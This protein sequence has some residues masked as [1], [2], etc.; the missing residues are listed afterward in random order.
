MATHQLLKPDRRAVWLFQSQLVLNIAL[1]IFSRESMSASCSIFIANWS[2]LPDVCACRQLLHAGSMRHHRDTLLLHCT[3]RLVLLLVPVSLLHLLCLE[4]LPV[5]TFDLLGSS[6]LRPELDIRV[7]AQLQTCCTL[8]SAAKLCFI[9]LLDLC[10]GCWAL[11]GS[12]ATHS[13]GFLFDP[14]SRS[15]K[16]TSSMFG[17]HLTQIW[18][19]RSGQPR[20]LCPKRVRAVGALEF[21]ISSMLSGRGVLG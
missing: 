3:L 9:Y 7:H 20:V 1:V 2:G 13:V 14:R 10:L 16:S 17:C 12:T 18:M 5:D 21:Y 11:G 6:Y 15:S 19:L 4:D 8:N